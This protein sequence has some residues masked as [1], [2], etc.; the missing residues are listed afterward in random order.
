MHR[1]FLSLGSNLGNRIFNLQK[2]LELISKHIGDIK[3]VGALYETEPWGFD[4]D[5]WFVNTAI[6]FDTIHSPRELLHKC[7][8]IENILGRER[9]KTK[10]GY[11]SRLIDIDI[12]FYDDKIINLPDLIIPHLYV[13]KR[14]FVLAPLND[15]APEFI[16]PI[17][18]ESVQTLFLNC[19]D[20]T[21]LIKMDQQLENIS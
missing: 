2:A 20:K 7:M 14:K 11:S 16:H 9:N 18:K 6:E 10:E 21:E 17:L 1:A 19:L 15:I 13:H 8:W 5:N 12:L 4:S 3:S